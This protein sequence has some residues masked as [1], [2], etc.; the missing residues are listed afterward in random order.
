MDL[1]ATIRSIEAAAY[2]SWPARE[3]V[4]YDGWQLRY[5]DGFSRRGNSVYPAAI[6]NLEIEEK[7]DW[8]RRWYAARDL[9]LVVRQTIATEP[10]LDDYLEAGGFSLEG[11]TNV[12]VAPL[13]TRP[14]SIVVEER[15]STTWWR[16]VADLWGFDLSAP[17]GW[18]AIV[19]RIDLPAGFVAVDG[20]AAGL[21]VV[22]GSWLGL[23]E[24]VVHPDKRREGLGGAVT[25]SLLGWGH[26]HGATSAYL[27]VVADNLAAIGLYEG[28]GFERLYSYWYRRDQARPENRPA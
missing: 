4:D 14:Q 22:D 8:C 2:R 27:Q 5:A 12:M 7:L 18:S 17:D 24:I 25:R 9:E 13:T 1:S 28:I 15:P 23:F 19:N 26:A 16:T 21:A 20:E 6:S 11:R 10:G 3:C